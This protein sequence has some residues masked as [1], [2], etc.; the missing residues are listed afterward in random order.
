METRN[1]LRFLLLPL[2]LALVTGCTGGMDDLHGWV[3]ET[4][5]RPGGRIEPLPQVQPY[6]T[7]AYQAEN[8]RSP[9]MPDRQQSRAPAGGPRPDRD[10]PRE[11]LEQY[12]LDTLRM[13]GT[14]SLQG[15]AYGLVQTRDGL[16]HR[17]VPG[18]YIGQNDGRIV[19][20]SEAEIRLEELV[21]DGMGGFFRRPAAIALSE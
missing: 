6:E 4:K 21:A 10:R 13:A 9:F 11:Y 19:D 18:Q 3:D 14:I 20:V 15:R 8:L 17:V 2:A 12:P 1:M 7:F 16:L 5:A